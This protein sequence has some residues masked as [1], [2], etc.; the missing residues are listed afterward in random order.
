MS[1]NKKL[2]KIL[3]FLIAAAVVFRL[4]VA[5]K[6]MMYI[7]PGYAPIDDDL[8]FKWAQSISAGQW[9]GDYNYLT[10][11]KYPFFAVYLAFI[12]KIGIPYLVANGIMWLSAAIV[13]AWAFKP[14]L[15]KQ[16]QRVFLFLAI[17]Y[18]P[19]TYAQYSL[20]VY[21]D[22]LYPILC[23]LFFVALAGAALRLK[24]RPLRGLPFYLIAGVGLGL[25]Y[26]SRE[27]GYWLLPFGFT[28][29][30][31][32]IVY[33]ATD[34]GLEKKL[35][36]I[37]Q[38]FIPYVICLCCV[39]S[40]MGMNYKYYGVFKLTDFNSGSFAGRYGQMTRLPQENWNEI[41]AVPV[42]VRELMYEECP[43][44]RQFRE[45]LDQEGAVCRKAY[46]NPQAEDY[47]SGSFY[48]ALRLAAQ[49]MGY[50][51]SPQKAEELWRQIEKEVKDLRDR[52]EES[53]KPRSSVTPPLKAE[54]ISPV[55]TEVF[56]STKSVVT[57]RGMLPY[58][59]DISRISRQD[60]EV[61]QG[62]LHDDCN[63]AA[64]ENQPYSYY[65]D[66]QILI[67][68]IM[69]G[70]IWGYRLITVPLLVIG[71]YGGIKTFI[72]FKNRTYQKQIT[73]FVLLG[74]LLMGLFRVFII[75]YMEI[76]AFGIGTYAMYLGAV[77]PLV[78]LIGFVGGSLALDFKKNKI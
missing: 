50:Y 6:Q 53:L 38:M 9:L 31:I 58:E 34:K 60:M 37:V 14:V 49:E 22:A 42:D 19:S 11:S 25:S 12:N 39:L 51:D 48:W 23:T 21:R 68:K 10:L 56:N 74:F 76:S 70:V 77:F 4:F 52:T 32:C 45:Y 47:R 44:F 36:R 28:A 13:A 54:Y 7:Y 55:I 78:L 35:V 24:E 69:I 75:S 63:Y 41:V 40:V 59:Y 71:I 33:I 65:T 43:T 62:Y 30:I 66:F 27:D 57:W 2:K 72:K 26:I 67:F 18:S 29:L 8:Y 20:R 64:A 1:E 16:W 17:L 46:W 73:A 61:W 5:Y 3:L 15:K